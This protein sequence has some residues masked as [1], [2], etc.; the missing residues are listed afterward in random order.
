MSGGTHI[1]HGHTTTTTTH[2]LITQ[3]EVL[4]PQGAL[5]PAHT[6]NPT[7]PH[8]NTHKPPAA[9]PPK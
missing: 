5:L 3:L 7:P 8:P 9:P 4:L 6:P 1:H 2:N